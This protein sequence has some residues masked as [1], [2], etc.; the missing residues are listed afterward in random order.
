[1][2]NYFNVLVRLFMGSFT[3]YTKYHEVIS[4]R[5]FQLCL[6]LRLQIYTYKKNPLIPAASDS[7]YFTLRPNTKSV[8]LIVFQYTCYIRNNYKVYNVFFIIL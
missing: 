2:I 4:H 1:M 5:N 6:Q 8:L 7:I 3:L